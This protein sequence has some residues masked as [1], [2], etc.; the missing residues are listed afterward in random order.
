MRIIELC[1][2]DE[3]SLF[4][5]RLLRI[6]TQIVSTRLSYSV[7]YSLPNPNRPAT[8]EARTLF[9]LPSSA[10]VG[11]AAVRDVHTVDTQLAVRQ[12]R[13]VVNVELALSSSEPCCVTNVPTRDQFQVS[14]YTRVST[15]F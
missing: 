15:G 8:G 12:I 2:K 6:S 5:S 11:T 4:G 3:Y 14:K 10:V 7:Q 13:A 9:A 1:P